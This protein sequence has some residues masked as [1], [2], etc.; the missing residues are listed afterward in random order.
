MGREL[1][2]RYGLRFFSGFSF[3]R[4]SRFGFGVGGV[5]LLEGVGCRGRFGGVYCFFV[6]F[7]FL[8]R[9]GWD[10]RG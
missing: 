1:S 9:G 6:I 4:F 8:G 5:G 10:L 7:L 3:Y 2:S